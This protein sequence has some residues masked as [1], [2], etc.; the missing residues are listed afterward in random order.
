MLR[1]EAP[2]D[3][4]KLEQQIAALQYQISIDANEA[5]KKIHE[6]ALRVLEGKWGGQNE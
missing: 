5:D 1:V 6:E 4:K 3:K 2:K